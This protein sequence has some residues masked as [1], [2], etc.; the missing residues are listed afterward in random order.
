MAR[1]TVEVGVSHRAAPYPKQSPLTRQSIHPNWSMHRALRNYSDALGMSTDNWASIVVIE[2]S[3]DE[4][5]RQMPESLYRS[6]VI[7]GC[8]VHY[9]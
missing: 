1:A 3:I 7:G 9:P 4:M 6:S 5:P 8:H 2:L